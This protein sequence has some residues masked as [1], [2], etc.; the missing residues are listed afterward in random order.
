MPGAAYSVYA[1]DLAEA[2]QGPVFAWSSNA[3]TQTSSGTTQY[4]PVVAPLGMNLAAIYVYAQ[5]TVTPNA[6]TALT[7]GADILDV[8]TNGYEVTAAVG[9]TAR[10]KTVSRK[11]VEEA[12][13]IFV[14]PPTSTT[15]AY[16]R[17]SPASF[18]ATT[19]AATV[20]ARFIIP[21]AGGQA[22]NIRFSYPGAGGAYAT[23][24][25]ITSISTVFYLYA[26]PTLSDVKT[27]FSEVITPSLSSGQNDLMTY[28]PAG[29]SADMVELI[30]T[31]WGS[32]TIQKIVVDGQS[33][34]GR[35]VDIED[36]ETG[37]DLQ[38]LY[39]ISGTAAN[40][41]NVLVNMH[42]QRADHLWATLGAAYSSGLDILFCQ[43]SGEPSIV[44]SPSPATTASTPLTSN[45]ASVGPGATVAPRRAMGRL[46][47]RRVA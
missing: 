9:G 39:P 10:C 21:A 13:R 22:A 36:T 19:T 12:E 23:S 42:Q 29:V 15:F 47:G 14:Q 44:P 18:T 17:A 20:N 33:G 40:Q 24:A 11:G 2:A 37:N 3:I 28:Q 27:A 8:V 6:A 46:G 16:P 26:I 25:S 7:S 45:T 4:M 34:I 1:Q 30:G 35:T 5:A 32:S 41:L 43:I 38:T 31:T